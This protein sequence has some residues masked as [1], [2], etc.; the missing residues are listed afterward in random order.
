MIK[1]MTDKAADIEQSVAEELGIEILPFVVNVG[2]E[3]LIADIKLSPEEF[4][5]KVRASEEVPTTSQM[6][7]SDVED[8]Y[9]RLCEDG[10]A[11]IH[12]TISSNGSGINNTSNL[13]A[14]QLREEGMDITV[15]D[16]TMFSMAIGA[17][18]IEAAKMARA[19][20]DKQEIIDYV[21]RVYSRDT[22]YFVVDDL[23]FL[24]RGGRIKATS[25]AISSLLDIKPI[26]MINDGLVEAYKKVRGL[27]KAISILCGY[28]EERMDHPEE[29]EIIILESDAADKVELL[30]SMLE[31]RV[32]PKNITVT[33]IGPI[34]TAHAGLGLVGLYFK[35]KE[36][37][38]NYVS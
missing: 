6:S 30:K 19:G 15:I 24:K 20:K 31:E 29:N 35:H 27:K 1:I 14:G 8:I 38:K 18:V 21:T 2:G 32:H 33:K 36:P 11:V 34:I 5:A 25:M 22:A 17:A 26:L 37:Y 9:R 4:Y 23:T 3:S 12:I 13:V 10:S 28:A 16:S 7:P